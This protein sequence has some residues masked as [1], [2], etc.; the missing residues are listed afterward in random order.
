MASNLLDEPIQS[1]PIYDNQLLVCILYTSCSVCFLILYIYTYV[2]MKYL[3]F[4]SN[5]RI[6]I[7]KN[8]E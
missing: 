5:L 1:E 4:S 7:G 2:Y 8:F 6:A 3:F